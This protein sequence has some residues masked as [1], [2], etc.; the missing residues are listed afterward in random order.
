[1]NALFPLRDHH[2]LIYS[3]SLKVTFRE[4]KMDDSQQIF[5][6]LNP[7]QVLIVIHE[8]KKTKNMSHGNMNYGGK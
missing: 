7:S 2:S 6:G 4:L 3:V 5:E 8:E 1:M